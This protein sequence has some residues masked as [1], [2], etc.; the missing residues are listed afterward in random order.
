[1]RKGGET[2]LL[3]MDEPGG[4]GVERERF[5]AGCFADMM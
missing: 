3:S 2:F 4:G 5:S 1:M